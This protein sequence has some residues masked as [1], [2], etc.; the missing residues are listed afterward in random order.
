MPHIV[1]SSNCQTAGLTATLAEIFPGNVVTPLPLPQFADTSEEAQFAEKLKSADIWVSLGHFELVKKYHL[2]QAKPGFRLIKAPPLGFAAFHPDL[3][4]ARKKSTGALVE[5]HYNSAIVV[6]AYQNGLSPENAA[7]LFSRS[8]FESLGYLDSWGRSVA[9]LRQ[10]FANYDMRNEFDHFYLHMKRRGNFMY[11]VNHPR[12][13]AIVQLGKIIATKIGHSK[14]VYDKDIRISDGLT[15]VIW[16][17]YPEV[18]DALALEG[19]SYH[20][21]LGGQLHMIGVRNYIDFAYNNYRTL[22]IDPADIAIAYF[23]ESRLGAVLG[24][25]AKAAR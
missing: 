17:L 23:D 10:V 20:W 14:D 15:D 8:T 19:G 18:A 2:Q 3:C 6:W 16:P 4:Y 22:N 12:S 1:I 5:P 24:A 7:R 25:Q 13:E 21:K 11:S 9:H